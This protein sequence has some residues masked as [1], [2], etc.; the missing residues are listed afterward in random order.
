ME[1]LLQFKSG[2]SVIPEHLAQVLDYILADKMIIPKL[3]Y[4]TKEFY[5]LPSCYQPNTNELF[6]DE[7]D[8]KKFIKVNFKLPEDNLIFVLSKVIIN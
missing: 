4:Y 5:I 6:I 7:K 2:I 8:K 1:G 3:K